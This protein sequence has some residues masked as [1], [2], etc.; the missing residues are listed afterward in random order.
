MFTCRVGLRGNMGNW[1][2]DLGL[3]SWMMGGGFVGLKRL[4]NKITPGSG[5]R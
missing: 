3:G 4:A 2:E 5:T 1:V